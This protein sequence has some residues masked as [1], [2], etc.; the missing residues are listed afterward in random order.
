MLEL[1]GY[2][3]SRPQTIWTA[4]ICRPHVLLR[5]I[6]P[7]FQLQTFE[8]ILGKGKTADKKNQTR[9]PTL[10]Y[11]LARCVVCRLFKYLTLPI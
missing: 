7:L 2:Q 4:S 11:M 8:N 1:E 5:K 3:T 10:F 6:D 9:F